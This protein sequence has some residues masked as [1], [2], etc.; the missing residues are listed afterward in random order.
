VKVA[1]VSGCKAHAEY[2]GRPSPC[3][4]CPARKILVSGRQRVAIK[5]CL[6]SDRSFHYTANVLKSSK[7]SVDFAFDG[8]KIAVARENDKPP[9][10]HGDMYEALL[11][12]TTVAITAN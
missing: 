6:L 5:A 4:Q 1:G 2:I 10:E 11:A 12:A 8:P 7:P 9:L 3:V